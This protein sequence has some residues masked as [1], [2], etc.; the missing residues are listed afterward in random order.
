[1]QQ[2]LL[3]YYNHQVEAYR[4]NFTKVCEDFGFDAIHDMRVAIKRLRAIIILAEKLDTNLQGKRVGG[5]VRRFFRLSGRMRDAQVQQALLKEYETSLNTDFGEYASY[6]LILERKSIKKFK[7]YLHPLSPND[8]TADLELTLPALILKTDTAGIKSAISSLIAKL[9]HSIDQLKAQQHED[10]HL[11]KIRRQLKQISYLLSVYG[12]KDPDF[13][14]PVETLKL[15][16]KTNHLLGKW[17]DHVVA[18][19]YLTRFLRNKHGDD[20]NGYKHYPLLMEEI[21]AKKHTL[22]LKIM[23]KMEK[24]DGK[25]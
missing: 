21:S 15:L 7:D 4:E 19:E 10:K 25:M 3:S 18:I 1:M 5:D 12:T 13:P 23:E 16:E 22:Y 17:H 2:K 24:S 20:S 6:L 14:K 8:F 9:F 11:H